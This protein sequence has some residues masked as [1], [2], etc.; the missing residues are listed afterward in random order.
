MGQLDEQSF[1]KAI[2]G[3]SKCDFKAFE[4]IAYLDRHVTVLAGKS[5]NDGRW[6][7]D[8]TD[9]KFF[10]G[11]FKIHCMSCQTVAFESPDCPRCHRANGLADAL[12]T[13]SRLDVP[14]TCPS[15]SGPE[16]TLTT[17][18][19][20][21]VKAVEHQRAVP[22]P[23]ALFGEA[24]YHVANIACVTCDWVTAAEGCPICGAAGPLRA[25]P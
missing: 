19:P 1:E 22:A 16:L 18:A 8:H 3:C 6:L 17:F 23:T 7:H 15:C 12:S 11:V 4:V 24:G 21:T 10:D 9:P 14:M 2:A 5:Q 13:M 25:R 20:A